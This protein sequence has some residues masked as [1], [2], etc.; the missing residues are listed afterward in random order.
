MTAMLRSIDLKPPRTI[1]YWKINQNRGIGKNRVPSCILHAGV[2]ISLRRRWAFLAALSSSWSASASSFP[3][4]AV[5]STSDA[6]SSAVGGRGRHKAHAQLQ[7]D[8]TDLGS[9]S[10]GTIECAGRKS[11]IEADC[12]MSK[13]KSNIKEVWITSAFRA[14]GQQAIQ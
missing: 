8:H 1:C 11:S 12:A 2:G 5:S 9:W 4:D 3:V 6:V 14:S 10:D 7:P 13:S